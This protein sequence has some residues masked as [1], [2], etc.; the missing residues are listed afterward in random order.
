MTVTAP[1]FSFTAFSPLL[2]LALGH[3]HLFFDIV[4]ADDILSE[5]NLLCFISRLS[6]EVENGTV[7]SLHVYSFCSLI[8]HIGPFPAGN[9]YQ[10]L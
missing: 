9:C 2:A 10:A 6:V 1:V 5:L 8:L 4:E 7:N 3:L